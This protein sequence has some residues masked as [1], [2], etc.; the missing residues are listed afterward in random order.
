[1][2]HGKITDRILLTFAILLCIYLILIR[3]C[4][5]GHGG[6]D[7]ADTTYITGDPDTVIIYDTTFKYV[8]RPVPVAKYKYVY[9]TIAVDSFSANKDLTCDTIRV[10]VDSVEDGTCKVL[11]RDSIRGE[12]LGWSAQLY[13]RNTTITRVDTMKITVYPDKWRMGIGAG[14]NQGL[15]LYGSASKGRNHFIGGYDFKSK[16]PFLGAGVMISK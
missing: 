8:D 13:S 9:D 11:L 16:S 4:G 15:M 2:D 1:M 7:A 5:D 14:I 12:L 10:Y 3:S 6:G